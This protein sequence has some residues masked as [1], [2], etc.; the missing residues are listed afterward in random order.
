MKTLKQLERLR[1]AHK[2][3][4]QENTGTP[5]EFANRLNISRRQLYNM[6]EYFKELDA[7]LL[8]NRKT[9]TFYYS[10]DFDL[11]VNVSVQVLVKDELITIYAGSTLLKEKFSTQ[12]LC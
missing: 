10:Y 9:N 7:P 12:I 2:L 5:E 11:L 6:I 8:Y 3:I 1:K 4:Q